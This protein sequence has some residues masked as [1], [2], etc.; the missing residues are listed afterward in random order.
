MTSN[1]GNLLRLTR[2][3]FFHDCRIGLGAMALGRNTSNQLVTARAVPGS[4]IP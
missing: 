4:A 2:R 3:H 1:D